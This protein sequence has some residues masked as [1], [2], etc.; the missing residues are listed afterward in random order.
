MLSWADLLISKASLLAF[1]A[2][3]ILGLLHFATQKSRSES[4]G[5]IQIVMAAKVGGGSITLTLFRKSGNVLHKGTL[6]LIISFVYS[7][8]ITVLDSLKGN[9]RC[10][11]VRACSSF[12]SRLKILRV[13]RT[14]TLP[15]KA[16]YFPS[17]ATTHLKLFLSGK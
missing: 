17:K 6:Q 3:V 11:S 7:E 14:K 13:P 8:S 10:K 16:L 12:S 9:L 15:K 2:E 4:C 5:K 1:A